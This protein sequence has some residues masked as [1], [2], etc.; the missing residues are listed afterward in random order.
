MIGVDGERYYAGDSVDREVIGIA[1]RRQT[2]G[3]T[4]LARR[5][6]IDWLVDAA[7]FVD[8]C[9]GCAGIYRR[10]SLVYVIHSKRNRLLAAVP[11]G[12]SGFH[13]E[14]ETGLDFEVRICN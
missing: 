4:G 8:R 14:G 6:G 7:I 12:V 13:G 9:S 11:S 10:S 1:T 3:H 2:P 5:C